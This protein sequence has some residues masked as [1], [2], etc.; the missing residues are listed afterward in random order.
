MS[1]TGGTATLGRK[2]L[3]V[4]G[5]LLFGAF[6]LRMIPLFVAPGI[7]HPDE[8]FQVI[9]QS[10]RLVYGYGIVPWEF[11]KGI[12]SWLLPGF[13]AGVIAAV[14][15][16]S[17]SPAVYLAAIGIVCALISLIAPAY[18]F[19]WGHRHFGLTGGVVAGLVPAFWIDTVYFATHPLTE[20][21]AAHLVLGGLL[22]AGIGR[23]RRR[24]A[25]AAG[26]ILALAFLIRFHLTPALG[27]AVLWLCW[28]DRRLVLPLVF[29]AV[30]VVLLGGLL[31]ALTWT[32]PWQSI[33][34]NFVVNAVNGVS[35]RFGETPPY[36]LLGC[37]VG[38]WSGSSVVL[39]GL[40][41]VGARRHPLPLVLAAVVFLSF[42]P[43]AH[44]E[45]RF[46][47]PAIEFGLVSAGLG[48]AQLVVWAQRLQP[49][50]RTRLQRMAVPIGAGAAFALLSLTTAA[51]PFYQDK[52]LRKGVAVV[53]ASPFVRAQPGL[54]G[55]GLQVPFWKT[56]GYTYF[57]VTVPIFEV[58]QPFQLRKFAPAF[59]VLVFQRGAKIDPGLGYATVRC[60]D[61]MCVARRPGGCAEM[62]QP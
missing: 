3:S 31:D 53:R 36:Y 2:E 62:H 33:W 11:V 52:V 39:A 1:P 30:P 8:V 60:F 17:E 37:L 20:V 25:V 57:H 51:A 49:A 55:I 32:Y 6:L 21:I 50:L 22:L 9:E 56:G 34:L 40:A 16:L 23:G 13:F 15:P 48:L 45:C 42:Q 7:Y 44:R 10:H 61:D 54:C 26:A 29:G 24:Y 5:A 19:V 59:N 27:V 35:E 41:L 47:Y 38:L 28:R 58:P 43:F 14:R 46:I 18:A 12:R 4:L